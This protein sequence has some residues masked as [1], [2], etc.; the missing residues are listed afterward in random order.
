[1]TTLTASSGKFR[2]T[3]WQSTPLRALVR[4]RCR[5]ES[6][7]VVRIEGPLTIV[8]LLP[9]SRI[10][11]AGM[12]AGSVL[13]TRSVCRIPRPWKLF[14]FMESFPSLTVRL[15]AMIRK[16][17]VRSDFISSVVQS[18]STMSIRTTS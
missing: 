15:W 2:L 11:S 10:L 13:L 17:T 12:S 8:A 6:S 9:S 16:V 7:I 4:A 18:S 1:M 14:A 5:G 3:T